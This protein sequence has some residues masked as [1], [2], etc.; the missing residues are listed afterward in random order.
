MLPLPP[1][2]LR[3]VA[4]AL[5]LLAPGAVSA[6]AQYGAVFSGSGPVNRGMG[7]VAQATAADAIG[8]LYWN[9]ATM[10]GLEDTQTS[11]GIELLY[12]QTRLAS[13]FAAG[14]LGPGAPPVPLS[15]SDR[16]DNGIFPLPS[17]AVVFKPEGSPWTFGIGV[18]EAGGFGVNYPASTSNPILTPQPPRGLGLGPLFSRLQVLEIAPAV[19]YQLT[20]RLAVGFSPSVDLAELEADPAFIAAPDDANRDGFRTFPNGTHTRWHWGGG[21]QAGAYYTLDNGLGLGASVKSPRWFERFHFQA[22]DEL[23]RPRNFTFAADLPLVVSVGGAY[24]GFQRWLL[25]AD[26]HYLD[27]RNARGIGDSG[28]SP[29]GAVHGVGQHS[30]W[31]V[32]L[33]AQYRLTDALAVRLGYTFN[34]N[35]IDSLHVSANVASPTILQHTISV[36]ASYRV[37]GWASLDL[38]YAHAFQNSLTGPL[39]GPFG[40]VPGTSITSVVSGDT[41]LVG[42]TLHFGDKCD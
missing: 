34:Q 19:S 9:P 10:S 37:T 40:A 36:G 28:F 38:A 27:F 15:G 4:V 33:G 21:F 17:G 23:G 7:G 30:I 26:L 24:T 8:A 35:P 6:R 41:F 16:A 5:V 29:D 1:T 32:A 2:W 18:F 14:A 25:G 22:T 42:A 31:A 13:T 11:F 12:P 3:Y 39:V 20:E